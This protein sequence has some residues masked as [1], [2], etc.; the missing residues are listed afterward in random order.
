M[1]QGFYR[2]G[3]APRLTTVCTIPALLPVIPPESERERWM[4][5]IMATMD[6]YLL[7]EEAQKNVS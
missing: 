3:E 4:E 2:E 6:Q 7:W 1:V 5:Q